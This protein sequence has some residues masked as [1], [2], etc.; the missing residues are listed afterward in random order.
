MELQEAAE[1]TRF[2]KWCESEEVLMMRRRL[3]CFKAAADPAV[4]SG[5]ARGGP[6]QQERG[7]KEGRLEV[8]MEG[9]QQEGT[10]P[11]ESNLNSTGARWTAGEPSHSRVYFLPS[12]VSNRGRGRRQLQLLRAT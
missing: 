6:V 9:H 7:E 8:M 3:C 4:W 10:Q 1:E 12:A 2:S 11:N 5:G